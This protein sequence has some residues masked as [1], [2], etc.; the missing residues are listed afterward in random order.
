MGG[1]KEGKRLKRSK[2]SKPRTFDLY[3]DVDNT[4]LIVPHNQE[5]QRREIAGWFCA[6]HNDPSP[7]RVCRTYLHQVSDIRLKCSEGPVEITIDIKRAK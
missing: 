7:V 6:K 2:S 3:G 1:L 5:M 4:Y